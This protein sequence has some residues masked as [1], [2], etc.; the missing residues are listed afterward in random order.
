MTKAP[1]ITP[2]PGKP[3]L[4]LG[5]FDI[6]TVGYSA[7]EF[8]ITGSASSYAPHGELGSDGRWDVTP[9]GTAEYTTRIVTLIPV[10]PT[11]FNGTV[12]VEWLNVS[13]GIDAPAVWMMAHREI[14][15]M[16]SAGSGA[17]LCVAH[18]CSRQ[19]GAQAVLGVEGGHR[20]EPAA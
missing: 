18:A 19:F 1:D 7:Q 8:F 5:A 16:R 6:A 10:G 13:G 15:A 20:G 9:C 3:R 2:V 14:A 4:L 12:L 17:G 11:R